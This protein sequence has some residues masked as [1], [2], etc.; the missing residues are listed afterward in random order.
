[1]HNSFS[2]KI[3]V[4]TVGEVIGVKIPDQLYNVLDVISE[5]LK[6][7][8][9]EKENIASQFGEKHFIPPIV[10]ILSIEYE[11]DLLF[12][13][14]TCIQQLCLLPTFLP[15]RRNQSV[16]QQA[17]GLYQIGILI[18]RTNKDKLLQAKAI[19]TIAYALFG[20]S[21][22]CFLNKTLKKFHLYQIIKKIK[23]H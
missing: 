17:N 14:L 12:K 16:F 15:C 22:C 8:P 13:C 9:S 20:R 7:A 21:Q 1:M 2:D 5:L 3:G 10:R 23:K 4:N 6:R 19:A 18:R 11:H